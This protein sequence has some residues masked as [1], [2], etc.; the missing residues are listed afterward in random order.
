MPGTG[1]V[2]VRYTNVNRYHFALYWSSPGQCRGRGLHYPTP[3][4]GHSIHHVAPVITPPRFSLVHPRIRAKLYTMADSGDSNSAAAPSTLHKARAFLADENVQ[5]QSREK[6][7]EFLRSKG[8][9]DDDVESLLAEK[10]EKD[11][12]EGFEPAGA[13]PT[14][15]E[16]QEAQ[17]EA[18]PGAEPPTAAPEA[19]GTARE[20]GIP[21]PAPTGDAPPIITYPEFLTHSPRPPPLLTPTR[22]LNTL[23]AVGSAWTLLYGA[24]RFVVNPMVENLNQARSD[25]YTHVNERL[26]PVVEKLEGDVSE[27]PYKNGKA[28]RQADPDGD[29][30]SESSYDD[31]TELFHRDVGTQTSPQATTPVRS[32]SGSPETP[33]DGQAR[34]LARL[35]AAVRELSDMKIKRAE[36]SADL[37]AMLREVRDDVDKLAYPPPPDYTSYGLGLSRPSEADDEYKKT[38][39]AIRSVKGVFLSSRMFP[40]AAAK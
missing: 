6:K 14:T 31:P 32:G 5:G 8:I 38:K 21:R 35:N 34:R 39:D 12:L 24:A 25:Y 22:V 37:H 16:R 10:D 7:A 9:S 33:I 28:L 19:N 29:A 2:S 40:A 3:G 27:V 30:G 17:Q 15:S 26:A 36:E 4:P 1:Q 11:A 20:V 23:T 13:A 18:S